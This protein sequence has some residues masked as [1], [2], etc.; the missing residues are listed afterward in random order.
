MEEVEV[1]QAL[2][3]KPFFKG[4]NYENGKRK[5]ASS[6]KNIPTSRVPGQEVG[7]SVAYTQT[8]PL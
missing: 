7:S 2:T 1:F 8:L 5:A 4:G 3:D 6:K